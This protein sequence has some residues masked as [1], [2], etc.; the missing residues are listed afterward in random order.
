MTGSLA[1]GN[2]TRLAGEW[3][4]ARAQ[5]VKA[6][7]GHAGAIPCLADATC[8]R[9]YAGAYCRDRDGAGLGNCHG[10]HCP[11]GRRLGCTSDHAC[12]GSYC[13]NYAPHVPPFVC[14]GGSHA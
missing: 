7:C 1:V 12:P 10:V 6:D 3:A 8:S 11:A 9:L 2:A 5:A 4:E 13:K 14:H